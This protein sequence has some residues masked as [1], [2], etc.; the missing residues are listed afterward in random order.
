MRTAQRFVIL[1]VALSS[2]ASAC[3]SSTTSAPGET[4]ASTLKVGF[5]CSCTGANGAAHVAAQKVYEAWVKTT[6]AAGGLDGHPVDLIEKDDATNPGVGVTAVKSLIAKGVAVL[7]DNSDVDGA[8]ATSVAAAKVPVIGLHPTNGPFETN[9]YFYPQGQTGTST[10][11]A[12]VDAVRRSGATAMGVLYCAEAPACQEQVPVFKRAAQKAGVDLVYTASIAGNAPN[13]TAQCLAAKNARVQA[14][15]VG[16]ASAVVARVAADCS[17]Q[18]YNPT[19]LV[20]GAVVVGS[21]LKAAGIRDDTYFVD[22]NLPAFSESPA[23]AAMNNAVDKYFP[24][25][26]D[27]HETF[28]D[29]AAAAWPAG[30]LLAQAVKAAGIA[31]GQAPTSTAIIQGLDSLSNET[32]DGWAPALTFAQGHL[33]TVD[34]FFLGHI[35]HGVEKVENGGEPICP[36]DGA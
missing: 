15:F 23:V 34:C 27:D 9:Q 8:W 19:Y 3:S 25:L 17:L 32:L 14:L 33:H 5:V 10:Y 6:N 31:S 30:L 1:A 4:S 28:T 24:G 26:R 22:P 18:D 13:Y 2:I 20:P 12:D 7:V 35:S 36:A 16:D 29:G 11:E 21:L